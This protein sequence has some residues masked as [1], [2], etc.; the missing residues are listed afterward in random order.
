MIS[1]PQ[2]QKGLQN[3]QKSITFIDK[4]HMAFH[5]VGKPYKTCGNGWFWE[6][7]FGNVAGLGGPAGRPKA[8]LAIDLILFWF[9][10][11]V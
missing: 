4:T 11:L 2:S 1:E 10:F 9:P 6:A 5:H 8:E 3:D 7:I